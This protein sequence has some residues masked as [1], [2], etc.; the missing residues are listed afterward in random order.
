MLIVLARNPQLQR[1]SSER[2]DS[3]V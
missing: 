3:R 2:F 1:F